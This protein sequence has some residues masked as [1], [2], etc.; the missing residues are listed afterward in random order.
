MPAGIEAVIEDGFATLD[1]TDRSLV[2][3]SLEKLR[4]AGS[5]VTKETRTGPRARYTMPEGD[6]IAAGL[7]DGATLRPDHLSYGD[8][9]FAESLQSVGNAGARPEAPTSR[10]LYVGATPAADVMA[11]PGPS[12]TVGGSL[13]SGAVIAPIHGSIKKYGDYS[14]PQPHEPADCTHP[15]DGSGDI[16]DGVIDFVEPT[17]IH[18]K[19]PKRPPTTTGVTLDVPAGASVVDPNSPGANAVWP[20]PM[21]TVPPVAPGAVTAPAPAGAAAK[22]APGTPLTIS[23]SDPSWTVAELKAYAAENNI[24]LAGATKKADI[25]KAIEAAG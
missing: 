15:G 12:T 10:N 14:L 3:P 25:L 6:A 13:P 7:L 11:V 23:S 22:S 2:G 9:G 16:A 24:D 21:P 18:S 8:S 19:A 4:L 5:K 1:F 20:T 17:R